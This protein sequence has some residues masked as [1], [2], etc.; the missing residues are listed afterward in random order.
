MT[1][2]RQRSLPSRG[3]I[4]ISLSSHRPPTFVRHESKVEFEIISKSSVLQAEMRKKFNT[5][6]DFFKAFTVLRRRYLGGGGGVDKTLLLAFGLPLLKR[7]VQDLQFWTWHK[8]ILKNTRNSSTLK[9][10][11]IFF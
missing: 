9:F 1:S 6:W 5:V 11:K 4:A 10:V 7:K 2:E 8:K 3:Y